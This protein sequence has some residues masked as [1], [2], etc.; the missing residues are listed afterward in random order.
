[1]NIERIINKI[2]IFVVGSLLLASVINGY[3]HVNE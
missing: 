1:M 3:F 2:I